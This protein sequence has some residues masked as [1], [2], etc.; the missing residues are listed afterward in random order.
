MLVQKW[1]NVLYICSLKAKEKS[2]QLFGIVQSVVIELFCKNVKQ[3]RYRPGVAQ[4]VPGS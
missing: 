1:T 3:S 2:L 4:R